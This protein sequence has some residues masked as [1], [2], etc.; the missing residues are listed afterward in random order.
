MLQNKSTETNVI[1]PSNKRIRAAMFSCEK[2]EKKIRVTK[3]SCKSKKLFRNFL[4]YGKS[5]ERIWER[6]VCARSPYSSGDL[7][8]IPTMISP[9]SPL[10]GIAIF[11]Y[12]AIV[13]EIPSGSV[14]VDCN[15]YKHRARWFH[16]EMVIIF[17]DIERKE[18]G[19][20]KKK[21][22]EQLSQRNSVRVKN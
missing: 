13:T 15:G 8:I 22:H 7:C 3:K 18:E 5:R 6:Y 17:G 14:L 2:K 10:S 12:L 20:R 4:D 21:L 1:A 11:P 19:K 9:H 16:V